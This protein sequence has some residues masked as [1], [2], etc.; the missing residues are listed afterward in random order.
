MSA[1]GDYEPTNIMLTGGAGF[2]G[3]NVLLLM[4]QKYPQYNFVNYDSLEYC[5]CLK[6][7][8]EI[9]RLKNYTFVQGDICNQDLVMHVLK[10]HRIDTIMHFA[11]QTH[12][13]NSFGNSFVF[14][15]TN[16]LG[17]HTLLESAKAYGK[18]RRFIH[19]STDEV[20]GE[21]D[22][23]K[24]SLDEDSMLKPTQPYAAAKAGAEHLVKSYFLSYQL[25]IIITRGNNVYGPCQFPEKVIP[26]FINLLMSDRACCLHGDGSARRSFLYASDVADAFDTILHKG[27]VGSVYN[28]GTDEEISMLDMTKILIKAMGK[29][30]DEKDL[31]Y[32]VEDRKFNDL[33]YAIKSD[34]LRALGWAP[35]VDFEAGLQKTLAW[36]AEHRGN[37][38]DIEAALVAHP[39]LTNTLRKD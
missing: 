14:T 10:T 26:K 16:V 15:R 23:D 6:N 22:L 24:D 7:L 28:I 3:S 37:W 34:R 27:E 19:V 17:T 8:E 38:G 12:V 32:F 11:A 21:V 1:K 39:R 4:V 25:P 30:K 36:Y 13:D 2:I 20:Y 31:M 5:A 9:S 33:R 18:I 35:K 29:E